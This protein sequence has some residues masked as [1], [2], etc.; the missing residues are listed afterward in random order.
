MFSNTPRASFSSDP[1]AQETL[2]LAAENKTLLD[3]HA[4]NVEGRS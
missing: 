2:R 4:N 3:C 1:G